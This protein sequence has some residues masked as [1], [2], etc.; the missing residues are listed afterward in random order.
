MKPIHI[1]LYTLLAV[2]II[3]LLLW[4]I[5]QYRVYNK[6]MTGRSI[7]AEAEFARQALVAQSLAELSAAQNRADAIAIVGEMAQRYPEYRQQ[8]FIGAFAEA[9]KDGNIEQILYIPTEAGI[10]ITEAGRATR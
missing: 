9:L 5:P 2:F 10:P 4:G 6:E 7:L 3:G 1:T 8:E